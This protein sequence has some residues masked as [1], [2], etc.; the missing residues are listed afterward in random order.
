MN[1]SSGT[2][3]V[4][5]TFQTDSTAANNKYKIAVITQQ[6]SATGYTVNFNDFSVGPTVV[7][8]GTPVTDWVSYTPTLTGFGTATS[9]NFQWRR[10]GDNVEV[11]GKFTSGTSTA[12]EGRASLPSVTSADTSKIASLQVVGMGATSVTA[13]NSRTVLI[14]PSVGYVTFGIS[15]AGP[16]AKQNG[17]ILLASGDTFSFF[18]LVPV[19]GWSS[20]VQISSD[21]DTRVVACRV[22]GIPTGTITS[23]SSTTANI[24]FPTVAFDT[25]A[26][27]SSGL[28]TVPVSGIYRVT[29]HARSTVVSGGTF[30]AL[31]VF[32]NN[33]FVNNSTVATPTSSLGVQLNTLVSVSAGQTI[34]VR[35]WTDG[36]TP[37]FVSDAGAQFLNIERLSGPSVIAASESVNASYFSTSTGAMA[38][39]T[40]ATVVFASKNFDSHNAYNT[41][42]GLYTAPISGKYQVSCTITTSSNNSIHSL[43]VE[44]WKTGAA[45]P[46]NRYNVSRL[47]TIASALVGIPNTVIN[48]AAGETVEIRVGITSGTS[49]FDG[50]AY[51]NNFFIT[52]VGN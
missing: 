3:V 41:T 37:T 30:Q 31:G 42:T 17:S 20:N 40:P 8:N 34:A 13:S 44:I 43:V 36:T 10:V 15:S 39:G 46:Y 6:T 1:T 18:A 50:N 27:Y 26:S 21:T 16:L 2:G 33:S 47:A 12:V 49:N 38:V 48:L 24:N 5:F 52:R 19:Q 35:L 11:R 51:G 32:V 29:S 22:T 28:Y 45:A 9:V 4:S 14:E 23:S 7:I 25:H